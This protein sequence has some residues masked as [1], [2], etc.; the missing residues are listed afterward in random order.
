[1]IAVNLGSDSQRYS[2]FK[3]LPSKRRKRWIEL[4]SFLNG[5]SRP[6]LL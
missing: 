4:I 2:E 3:G 1:M 5:R 6:I